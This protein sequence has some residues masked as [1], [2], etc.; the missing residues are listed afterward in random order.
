LP[1]GT[2]ITVQ[3]DH[4]FSVARVQAGDSFAASLVGPILVDGGILIERRAPVVGVVESTQPA[5]TTPG[6]ASNPALIRLTLNSIVVEG[7]PV[8]VQTSSLFAK[9][10]APD[11][12]A[13]SKDFQLR[14]GHAFT[15]RLTT[16][17][18]F[19]DANSIADRRYSDSSK[20][21]TSGK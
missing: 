6:G 20:S 10:S 11:T 7:R 8:A 15:F 21:E 13:S 5:A 1:A 16:S 4:S 3:L 9:G 18:S 12:N 17:V 14:K 19:T 2:L